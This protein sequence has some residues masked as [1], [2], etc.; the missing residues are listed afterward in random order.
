M[1]AFQF[2]SRED[3]EAAQNEAFAALAQEMAAKGFTLDKDGAIVSRNARTGLPDYEAPRTVAW[4][5]VKEAP[6]GS[7]WFEA[8]KGAPEGATR[9]D[10]IPADW[11]EKAQADV[12]KKADSDGRSKADV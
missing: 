1:S 6:D 2:A 12:L 4:A 3:A 8:G 5:D 9:V 10:Q 11:A 7:F